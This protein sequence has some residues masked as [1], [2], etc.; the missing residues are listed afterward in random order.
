MRIRGTAIVIRDTR[1]LLVQDRGKSRFSLPGGGKEK[2]EPVLATAIRELYEELGM[3]AQKAER[4][5][6]CDY[7]GTVNLHQ[8]CLIETDDEPVIA[9]RELSHFLWW[10][11]EQD[12]PRLPHVDRILANL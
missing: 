10:D 1:I 12:I 4:L 8:V 3:N 2:N 9:S 5:L 11:Q 7:T 6:R